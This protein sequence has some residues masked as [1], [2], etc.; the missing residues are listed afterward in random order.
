MVVDLGYTHGLVAPGGSGQTPVTSALGHW[1]R[2]G[3][4][5]ILGTSTVFEVALEVACDD[6]SECAW[7]AEGVKVS[8][9]A[10][11]GS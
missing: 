2:L 11:S 5:V 6:V 8:R 10:S 4:G 1:L 9:D 7:Q 3:M